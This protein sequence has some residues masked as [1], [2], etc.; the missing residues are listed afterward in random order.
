MPMPL[1]LESFGIQKEAGD[2][3]RDGG[4]YDLG[5]DIG[6]RSALKDRT[7][8]WIQGGGE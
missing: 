1:L 3:E 2:I 4:K 6:L 7:A 5:I 8:T